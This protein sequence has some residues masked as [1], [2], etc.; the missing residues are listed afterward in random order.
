MKNDVL[1]EAF[2]EIYLLI[3]IQ[4]VLVIFAFIFSFS[5][6]PEKIGEWYAKFQ[7]GQITEFNRR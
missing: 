5:L 2:E 1:R 3:K 6:Y 4:L 7:K